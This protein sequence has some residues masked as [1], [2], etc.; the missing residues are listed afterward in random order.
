MLNLA[1]SLSFKNIQ[2]YQQICQIVLNFFISTL[3]HYK[4]SHNYLF[5]A[6]VMFLT[7]NFYEI[8]QATVLFILHFCRIYQTILIVR[9]LLAHIPIRKYRNAFC[10]ADL[11]EILIK[12]FGN[13]VQTFHTPFLEKTAFKWLHARS[14]ILLCFLNNL[15]ETRRKAL[16]QNGRIIKLECLGIT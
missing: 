9:R 3:Y 10:Y 1:E 6:N 7:P 8:L 16:P 4:E 5:M 13:F 14:N 2:K 11:F 12:S 15:M